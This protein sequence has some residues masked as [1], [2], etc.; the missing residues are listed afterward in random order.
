MK[1]LKRILNHAKKIWSI[2]CFSGLPIAFITFLLI[3]KSNKLNIVI[4]ILI[5]IFSSVANLCLYLYGKRDFGFFSVFNLLN[6]SEEILKI[7]EKQYCYPPA[8]AEL[9]L[10]NS[11]IIFGKNKSGVYGKPLEMDGH[12]IC[13]G[14]SGSG[15]SSAIC[16]P[17]IRSLGKSDNKYS[18]LVIDIKGELQAKSNIPEEK[19]I[20]FNPSDLISFGY[21]PFWCI[22][23]KNNSNLY[24]DIQDIS[25]ALIPSKDNDFWEQ[26][27]Q[28]LLSGL[29]LYCYRSDMGFIESCKYIHG[30]PIHEIF[31]AIT[32]SEFEDCKRAVAN[33][34]SLPDETLLGIITGIVNALTIYAMNEE[35]QTSLSKFKKFTLKDLLRNKFIFLTIEEDKL[36][37]YSSLLRL[38][39]IQTF[40]F[41]ERL[42]EDDKNRP[43][44]AII[45]DEFA[46]LGYVHGITSALAT[47]RSKKVTVL[48]LFQSISQLSDIYGADKKSVI[49]DNALFKII[50]NASD[51]DSQEYLS[52]LIGTY[53]RYTKSH[54]K[55][56]GAHK[57]G[58]S[59]S[60]SEQETPIVKP[61][62]F[63]KQKDVV[64]VSKYGFFRLNKKPYYEDK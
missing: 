48:L 61:E 44:I 39:L 23:S 1:H 13:I 22:Q 59:V 21:D 14:G 34:I 3:N 29:L 5:I 15:K 41:I 56:H 45:L 28:M 12:V 4:P 43:C 51:K 17:T 54:S 63:A 8:P 32:T 49:I 19:K 52:K 40:R 18:G 27:S 55:N 60:I 25:Y 57:G 24:G 47:S 20:I 9:K 31:A 37:K 64:I 16:I 30:T 7:K 35:V 6:L 10:H 2:I 53:P 62:E 33:V 11:G 58:S 46:R 38:I 36:E 42:P 26:S 50:L